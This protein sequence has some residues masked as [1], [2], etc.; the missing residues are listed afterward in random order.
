MDY[1]GV[2]TFNGTPGIPEAKPGL[3]C[4]ALSAEQL[5]FNTPE[6]QRGKT[7]AHSRIVA[8]VSRPVA[9]SPDDSVHNCLEFP[10]HWR[11]QLSEFG[12]HSPVLVLLSGN[13]MFGSP[14]GDPK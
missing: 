7:H 2:V 6:T 12:W 8:P 11:G 3:Q 14:N 1:A 4:E 13:R 10:K 5:M 9:V